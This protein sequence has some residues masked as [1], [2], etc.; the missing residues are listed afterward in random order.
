MEEKE[1]H[2]DDELDE[3]ITNQANQ[4]ILE[5]HEPIR[6]EERWEIADRYLRTAYKKGQYDIIQDMTDTR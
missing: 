3:W 5:L 2:P 4:M 1:R 6:N